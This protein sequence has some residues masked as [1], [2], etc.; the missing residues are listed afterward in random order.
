LAG[1][2]SF[3][4]NAGGTPVPGPKPNILFILVDELRYPAVF[5]DGIPT[6][7]RFLA[8]FMP[9]IYKRLWTQGVKFG[10]Y[11]TAVKACT[12]SRSV[13]ITGLYSGVGRMRDKNPLIGLSVADPIETATLPARLLVRSFQDCPGAAL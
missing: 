13:M 4:Q 12:P 8:R 10:N 11:H 1:Y 3:G 7:D 5:P 6:P 9:N 2:D